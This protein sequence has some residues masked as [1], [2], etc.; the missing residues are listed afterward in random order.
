MTNE[1]RTTEHSD[2][3][4]SGDIILTRDGIMYQYPIQNVKSIYKTDDVNIVMKDGDTHPLEYTDRLWT[5]LS[6]WYASK[7][8]D[9]PVDEAPKPAS[10]PRKR[11]KK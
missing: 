1:T 11:G 10:Q 6:A 4:L 8:V 2:W 3:E 7:I 9:A 5:L